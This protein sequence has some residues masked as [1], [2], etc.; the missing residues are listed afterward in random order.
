MLDALPETLEALHTKYRCLS[1]GEV[2]RYIPEL[3]KADPDG[4]CLAVTLVDGTSYVF[5]DE[6]TRF[7]L[8]SVA[9]PLVFGMALMAAGREITVS[10]TGVEPTGSSFSSMVGLDDIGRPLNPMVN[11]GAIVTSSLIP[12]GTP[13]ARFEHV[14]RVVRAYTGKD[15]VL[16]EAVYESEVRTGDRNRAL[17]Y[18]LKSKGTIE[19]DVSDAIDLYF[20]TCSLLTSCRGVADAAA[21]LANRGINPLRGERVIHETYI[22]DIL[23]VMLMNGM[24]NYAGR[25]AYSVGLPA[26]SGVSGAILAVVPG[27]MGIGVYSPRLDSYGNSVRG[28]GVCRE[29]VERY[30][31]HILGPRMCPGGDI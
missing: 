22:K 25:W 28:L 16:D 8:Q 1:D 6:D 23:V 20:R 5:G 11:A 29:L 19:G 30:G 12:G 18:L 15:A 27:V 24:Y 14:R 2:A 26:K 13:E 21:T 9:K 7:T 3:S 4:F 31:L 10:L 17:G